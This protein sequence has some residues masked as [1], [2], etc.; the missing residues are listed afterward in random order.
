VERDEIKHR[1]VEAG[2]D[3]DSSFEDHLLIGH[4]GYRLSLLAHREYWGTDQPIF[5]ILDHEEMSTYWVQEV[6]PRLSR[7]YSY[8]RS[9]VGLP[10][11]GIRPKRLLQDFVAGLGGAGCSSLA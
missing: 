7:P 3:L 6:P 8:S 1:F 10:R 11:S 5:E 2:L 9:M 4:G